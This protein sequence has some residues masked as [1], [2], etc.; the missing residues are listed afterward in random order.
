MPVTGPVVGE[1]PLL[2]GRLDILESGA[3]VALGIADVLALGQ[4][5]R[6]LEHVERRP[7]VTAGERDQVV[8]GLVRERDATVRAERPG[9]APIRVG[10]RAPHDAR[11]VIVAQRLEPPDA[12]PRQEGGV[13]L[14]VGVLGRRPDQGDGAV[15]DMGQQGVLLGLVEAMDLVEEEQRPG[16]VQR[17]PILRLGDRRAKLDHARHD[18]RHRREVGADLG[19]EQPGKARLAGA[20]R[21]PQQERREV[22][23]GD[24]PP[25]RSALAD[26]VGLADEL[27]QVAWAHPGGQRL[28]LGRRL[29][30]GLGAGAGRSSGGWH[31]R[32]VA[33]AGA[34]TRRGER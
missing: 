5:G 13:D 4:R 26:E 6:A 14:E 34:A 8:E 9:Q 28:P 21:P 25:E 2:G 23:A 1:D 17:Q 3:H 27:G 12:H 18:R 33:R 7:G 15:L 29:E 11:D 30:Q 20:R 32:M 22:S 24:A 10:D 31:A 16:A 19:R